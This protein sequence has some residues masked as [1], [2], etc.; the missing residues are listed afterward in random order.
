M[1]LQKFSLMSF[2]R[3]CEDVWNPTLGRRQEMLFIR[4]M[5]HLN[6]QIHKEKC[7]D[8]ISNE[9]F[10]QDDAQ[11]GESLK[12][13]NTW[14]SW[15]L[16]EGKVL[17]AMKLFYSH[18]TSSTVFFFPRELQYLKLKSLFLRHPLHFLFFPKLDK[19]E[20]ARREKLKANLI[21]WWSF[22]RDVSAS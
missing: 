8:K 1:G 18:Q 6:L 17:Q 2:S 11:D 3:T 9:S 20:A 12:I 10:H 21:D 4:L 5:K 16:S 14:L 15:W 19:E 22:V 7:K 13:S